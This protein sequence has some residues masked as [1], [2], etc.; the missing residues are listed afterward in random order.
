MARMDA[1]KLVAKPE[2]RNLMKRWRR[3]LG[4]T[5][6]E[7]SF[8]EREKA[9]LAI[10]NE[11]ARGAL[12][13]ELGELE[14]QL[15]DRVLVDGVEYKRHEP[16]TVAY[17]SLCGG[18]V[19]RRHTYR[20]VGVHNGP[21]LVPLELVAGLV[22]R[23]TPA[24]A[25]SVAEG[26]G[27]H[28]M[29]QHGQILRT[30]HR[31]P[32][33][34]TALEH[35]ATRIANRAVELAP[36]I[37]PQLRRAERVPEDATGVSIGLDRTA[38][39]MLEARPADAPP[40]PEPKRRKPRVRTPPPPADINWRMAYVGTVSFVDADGE[41][42]LARRYAAP[43]CDDP[44]DLVTQM[45][46]D[47]RS[48]V[49]RRPALQVG[50]MQDG[51]PEMWN[52]TREGLE[53]LREE[54]VITGWQEGIDRYHLLERLGDALALFDDDVNQRQRL[55]DDWGE[56]FDY[57]DATIETVERYLRRRYLELASDDKQKLW[58]HLTFIRNNKDRMH[59]GSLR[60]LGLPVGSGVTESAARTVVGQRAKG[61]SRRWSEPNLR[62]ALTLRAILQSDRLP[63]FWSRFAARYTA[64][65]AEA[66]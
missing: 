22:E 17:Y 64:E 9:M 8:A 24:M 29:R 55:L 53:Q 18:L 32:P 2:V 61:R 45:T 13:D 15:G 36:S 20:Q 25:L 54:R 5:V 50:I 41:T 42:I 7:A 26:Y 44:R 57:D 46:A 27:Q 1:D 14:C 37:E 47:V 62:G 16:G 59:Y 19:V 10:T 33:S 11:V 35:L 3:E 58:D 23:A 31:K 63:Q 48:A 40:K 52:R 34:R 51:A 56:R 4:A 39:A 6:G 49:R 66:V 12:E 43:A 21:T 28:D 60:H 30:A 38:V 65:V